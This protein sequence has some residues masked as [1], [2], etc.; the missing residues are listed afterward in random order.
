MEWCFNWDD[1][2]KKPYIT[3]HL[4]LLVVKICTCN[5]HVKIIVW[6]RNVLSK[7]SHMLSIAT[8]Y[9]TNKWNGLCPFRLYFEFVYRGKQ[10]KIIVSLHWDASLKQRSFENWQMLFLDNI[11]G[12]LSRLICKSTTTTDKHLHCGILYKQH[13]AMI[14]WKIFIQNVD[15][16]Q[17]CVSV[18]VSQV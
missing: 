13:I 14:W 18:Q 6:E 10:Q 3:C 9:E 8:C 16:M 15:W 1:A 17:A 4:K 2:L 12:V 11:F 7:R 5:K